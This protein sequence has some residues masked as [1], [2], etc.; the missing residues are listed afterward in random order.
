MSMKVNRRQLLEGYGRRRCR[1]RTGCPSAEI[2]RAHA[3]GKITVGMEAG[4]PY[5]TFYNK[6]A[7]EFTKAT[8]VEVAFNAIPHDS[9]RQQFVQDALSGA[10]GFDVYI[11]DQVWLPEFYREGLHRRPLR[12]ARRDADKADFA[13]TRDRDRLLQGRDRGAADHGA[14]LRHV[15]PHRSLRGGRALG[16]AGDLGRVPR[17][18]PRSSPTDAG[19][20]GTLIA[21]KQGIEASTRLHSFYQ[22]AGGDILDASGKPTIDSDAGHTALEFMTKMDFADKS[23][24]EGVLELSDMQGMWLDGKLAHGAGVAVPLLAVQGAARRASSRSARAPGLKKRRRH[25]LFVGLLRR[26]RLEEPGRPRSNGSNGRPTP[27]CSTTSA[28]SGSTRCRAPRRST[29]CRPTPS[30]SDADKAAIAAFATSAAAGTT[31][32]MVPQYSQL[33]DVLGIIQS[34]VMSK[35]MTHRRRAEGRP[36]PR[37]RG[38]ERLTMQAGGVADPARPH[39]TARGASRCRA[40]ETRR[41][42]RYPCHG[43]PTRRAISSSPIRDRLEPDRAGAGRRSPLTMLYPIAWTVWLSLNGKHCAERQ[44]GL[45]RPRQ[46]LQDRRQPRFPRPRSS[47]RSA[48]SRRALVLEARSRPRGRARAASRARRHARLPRH[49]RLPLM[50]APV[51]G[52]LAWR[53]MFVDGYGMIDT[54]ATHLGGDGPLWFADVWLAR[55]TIVITNLWLALPFDILVLLAGLA[56][57]PSDPIEAARVDGASPWQMLRLVILP[58]LRPVI[59]IIFVI[60]FA[61]AFRIFDVVYVLTG[62]GPGNSTDVLSTFIYRQMFTALRFRR[63][64]GRVDPARRRHLARLARSPCCS[65]AGAAGRGAMSHGSRAAGVARPYALGDIGTYAAA[66]RRLRALRHADLL[67]LLDL[68]QAVGRDSRDADDALPAASRRSITIDVAL[69]GDFRKFLHQQPDRRRRRRPSSGL[70]LS[71][72][73]AFGFAKYRYRGSG[74]LLSFIRASRASSRRSRWRCPSSSSSARS[75]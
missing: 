6:H 40:R 28:R 12:T 35:A 57:L 31:M 13:K 64:R 4:S 19:V 56:S 30:I 16:A 69:S 74:S 59:A 2:R 15:L 9:I 61:D 51:V 48:S 71:V 63:R 27:T 50:V 55:A 22:Q 5:D 20:W 45:R 62:S 39:R 17:H 36:A 67:D 73:A 14:Q 46:L 18:S 33:L 42:V 52:A 54:I 1:H 23:A 66:R 53:F 68:V 8:G 11:A 65:C 38:D 29:R 41:I 47:R 75:V 70:L 3:G 24:P 32:T 72:P 58:L 43:N 10:G 34:S 44:A 49:R 7:A 37:R 21:R 26:G 60:R 25:R